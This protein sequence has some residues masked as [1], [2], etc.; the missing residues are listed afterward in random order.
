M[1]VSHYPLWVDAGNWWIWCVFIIQRKM[2]GKSIG[3][4]TG[5]TEKNKV[6]AL[7]KA[8]CAVVSCQSHICMHAFN[9]KYLSMW[10][11]FLVLRNW[12]K[13]LDGCNCLLW[14]C[15]AH[16]ALTGVS[17]MP[18]HYQELPT[19]LK[20]SVPPL[21]R[22]YHIQVW[23]LCSQQWHWHTEISLLGDHQEHRGDGGH[24]IWRETE[25]TGFLICKKRRGNLITVSKQPNGRA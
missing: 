12:S 14:S 24:G 19:R 13:S 21:L 8:S 5:V 7:Q 6:M 20:V 16:L 18:L 25:R 17:R 22:T 3:N 11:Y 9:L 23:V 15:L 2:L 10:K 1:Q 4:Q